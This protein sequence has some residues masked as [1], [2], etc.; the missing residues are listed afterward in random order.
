VVAPEG[1]ALAA[2]VPFALWR[3]RRRRR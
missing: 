2:V 1:V 3:R